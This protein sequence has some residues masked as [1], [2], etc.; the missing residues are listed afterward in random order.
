MIVVDTSVWVDH[1]RNGNDQLIR[2]LNDER[3]MVHSFVTGE[4]ACGN[5]KNRD[6]ILSLLQTLPRPA[7]ADD[8]EMLEFIKINRLM[9]KGIGF[10]DMHLLASCVLSQASL[11]TLDKRLDEAALRLDVKYRL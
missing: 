5:L 6:E 7:T 4:L 10:I 8:G 9:G 1:F 11:F 3:V 2:L